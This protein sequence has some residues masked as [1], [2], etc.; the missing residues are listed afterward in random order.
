MKMSHENV[1][2]SSLKI[3][4]ILINYNFVK[5]LGKFGFSVFAHAVREV[6]RGSLGGRNITTKARPS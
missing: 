1:I 6:G 5:S 3:Q 2:K 4:H